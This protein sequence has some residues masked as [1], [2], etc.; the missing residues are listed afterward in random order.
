[1]LEQAWNSNVW[2]EIRIVVPKDDLVDE[3]LLGFTEEDI[4]EWQQ[5]HN[6]ESMLEV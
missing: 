4:A 2:K 6:G 3:E 1:M 5:E